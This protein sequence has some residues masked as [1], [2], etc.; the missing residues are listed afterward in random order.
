MV[1]NPSAVHAFGI[2]LILPKLADCIDAPAIQQAKIPAFGIDIHF[3]G[4]L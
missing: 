3:G 1:S 2:A 4:S